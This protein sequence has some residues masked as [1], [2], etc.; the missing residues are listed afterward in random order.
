MKSNRD[1]LINERRELMLRLNELLR[2]N[3]MATSM[4][5]SHEQNQWGFIVPC[6]MSALKSKLYTY[7]GSYMR[8][9]MKYYDE[10]IVNTKLRLKELKDILDS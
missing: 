5:R 6:A 2:R 3:V 4:Y 8:Y 10:D 1:E 9:G 7:N